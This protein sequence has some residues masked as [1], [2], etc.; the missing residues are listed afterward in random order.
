[1]T[2]RYEKF[3]EDFLVSKCLT[4]GKHIM[5]CINAPRP[6]WFHTPSWEYE[7]PKHE[8]IPVEKKK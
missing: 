3:G 7:Q 6:G 4:C 5:L 1:M 2:E 8:A